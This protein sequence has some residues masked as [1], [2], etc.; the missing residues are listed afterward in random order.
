MDLHVFRAS[1]YAEQKQLDAFSDL[2]R[3]ERVEMALRLL[4]I[5]PVDDARTAAR[6]E[7]RATKENATQLLG[8]VPD[9]AALEADLKDAAE[10]ATEAKRIVKAALGSRKAATKQVGDATQAFRRIDQARERVERLGALLAEKVE[11]R[12]E[13]LAERDELSERL[14]RLAVELEAL[15]DLEAEL[16]GLG[17]ADDR[18]RLGMR[19]VEA[20]G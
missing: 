1:V 14:E 4:G 8:A 11:R 5:K 19:F 17:D 16:T 20:G 2:R 13:R 6:R 12:D 9:L 18:L 10:A 3:G 15:P 7:A